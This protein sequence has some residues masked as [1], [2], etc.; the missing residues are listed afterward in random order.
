MRKLLLI[1]ICLLS[2]IAP[3]NVFAAPG[4]EVQKLED[5][6]DRLYS[7]KKYSE[8]KETFQKALKLDPN[9]PRIPAKLGIL[10]VLSQDYND[11]EKMLEQA[12]RQSPKDAQV[13]SNYASILLLNQKPEEAIGAAKMSLQIR[14]DAKTY[15][16]L[17]QAY[18]ALHNKEMAEIAF[19]KG[20]LLAPND[21]DIQSLRAQLELD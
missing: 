1:G 18:K 8:A 6:G 4:N 7:E 15:T 20:L 9:A 16:T 21:P 2:T 14:P 17:A 11:A 13:V 19:Q 10:C 12:V 5:L 3:S